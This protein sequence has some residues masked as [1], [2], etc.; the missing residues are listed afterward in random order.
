MNVKSFAHGAGHVLPAE[1]TFHTT[2]NYGLMQTKALLPER[3]CLACA[4][5]Q[6]ILEY[7]DV[8]LKNI[9]KIS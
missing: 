5:I 4:K 1:L 8:I 3:R 9:P 2:N 7:R 6:R